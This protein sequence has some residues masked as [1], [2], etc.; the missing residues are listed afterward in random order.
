[1]VEINIDTNESQTSIPLRREV[2]VLGG[3]VSGI[4]IASVLAQCG[5]HVTIVEKADSLGGK[6]ELSAS[7][8]HLPG[9][10]GRSM[11][12][13]IAD[14]ENHKNITLI[15]GA[16]LR[17]LTGQFGS[18]EALIGRDNDETMRV[19]AAIVVAAVGYATKREEPGNHIRERLIYLPELEKLLAAKGDA[20]LILNGKPIESVTFLL[21]LCN[22]DIKIDALNVLKQAL[23]LREKFHSQVSVLCKDLKVS[24][25]SGERLY[26]RARE[27]G[28]LFF[29][30]D[31][32]PVIDESQD[33]IS[34]KLPDNTM[35]GKKGREIITL[36]SDLLA[37]PETCLPP[38]DAEN[39]CLV[40]GIQREE[41]GYLMDDN[42][43]L[44]RVRSNR[45][46]IFVTGACRSPQGIS[47]TQHEAEAAAQEIAVLL[48]SGRYNIG[49]LFAEVDA[50]K[51]AL[52]YTCPR[53]CPHAAISIEKY[54]QQNV[55]RTFNASGQLLNAARVEPAACYGCGICV[56]ECPA[57]AISLRGETAVSQITARI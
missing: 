42:P 34:V 38:T 27:A 10:D 4:V 3:G 14:L 39:I 52:C 22:E 24:F 36:K 2:L 15:M 28:V 8:G 9:D 35:I 16:E 5:I 25:T 48:S 44:M 50:N 53:L 29:K 19:S 18:F 55:Y 1:M 40:L 30:Y 46:G 33:H 17:R 32:N 12:S 45:R 6:M 26:L 31:E 11:G 43:Q 41:G 13:V 51:C 47:E 21:D 23:I 7:C 57:Q 56:A 49:P 54:T 37:F 20:P